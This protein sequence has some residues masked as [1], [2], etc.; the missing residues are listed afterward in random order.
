MPYKYYPLLPP[1]WQWKDPGNL[2]II[3]DGITIILDCTLDIDGHR[4]GPVCVY[5]ANNPSPVWTVQKEHVIIAV[6]S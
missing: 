5:I 2:W 6:G 1:H 3:K 4:I